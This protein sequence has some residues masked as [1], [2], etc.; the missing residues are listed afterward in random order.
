VLYGRDSER[1]RIG[2]LLDDARASRSGVVVVRGE[3]GIGKTALLD[4]AR[5]RAADMHVLS[6]RGVE[7]ESELPFAALHQLLRPAL[8]RIDRLPAPQA[9]AL[10]AALGL[11]EGA[12]EE[13][14]LVFAA[15][16]SLLAELAERRP[17]LCLV[18]D[19]HW[20]D[21]ASSDALRFVAR[22]LDAEGIA[23][24]FAARDDEV[25][26]FDAPGLP[27][28]EL[29]GLGAE[30]AATLLAAGAGVDAA[31]A[32]RD[33]L[34]EWTRGNALALVELPA[35]LTPDQLAGV[36]PLPEALPVTR[37]LEH[38]FLA[39]A[40]RL[41]EDT[42]RLLLVA[43]A[44]D[45]EDLAVVSRA[46]AELG[47]PPGALDAAEQAGLVEVHGVRI[48]F[49]HP[50]VRSAVYEAASSGER[51]AAH[52]ALAGVLAGN[53]EQADRRAWH[54]AWS[55]IGRDESVV[56]ALD[57]AAQRAEARNGHTAA[58]KAFA[59]AAELSNDP[60]ERGRRLVRAAV[61]L[62]RAG[63]DGQAVARAREAGG[64]VSEPA[65]RA[66]L[67]EV[68]GAAAIRS[69]RPAEV[70]GV[71]VD[72]ARAVAATDPA[73]A[74]DLLM[75]A[76]QAAWAGGDLAAYLG[77]AKLAAA[78][79]PQPEDETSALLARSLAG[80]AAMIEGDHATGVPILSEVRDWGA[81]A[82]SP[83]SAVWAS[84]AALWL[85]DGDG[86]AALLDR[87]A[88]V[89]RERGE[90]GTLADVLGMRAARLATVQD[91][92]QAAVAAR[93]AVELSRDLGAVNLELL[94]R[95]ALAIVAAWRGRDE[96]ARREARD[97]LARANAGGLQLRASTAVYALALTELAGARWEPALE[98]LDSLVADESGDLDPLVASLLPDRIEA[99]VRLG[100]I[101]AARAALPLLETYADYS[102]Q[103]SARARL[104]A[105]RAL[106]A[107]GDEET[108]AH[109]EEAVRLGAD[110]RPLDLAGIR[111]LYGE[112]LR[113]ERR[114]VEA[115]V[116]L[117]AALDAFERR[118]AEPWAERA[119]TEL[120]AAGEASSRRAPTGTGRLTAQELQVARLVAQGLS[121][122]EVA[123]Q[124]FLSPRTIDAHLR[125][126]FAKLELT[127]RTQLA[128][129]V[130]A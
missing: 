57:D 87:A 45:S 34:V 58:A 106:L 123:A 16:L 60:G 105:S 121:N 13:R 89:A 5:E 112:Y 122:K 78:E 130:L 99:A 85:G 24:V 124:L 61:N 77:I 22:R 74:I 1:D 28:L 95:A 119:R 102:G 120:R 41:P 7:A 92:D 69:G 29:Q 42:Q 127:S 104:A 10:R 17:V 56:A 35:A 32:V 36:Q 30:A 108:V 83:R 39:R 94:P 84:F 53:D 111:L 113:R 73:K 98:L 76:S 15:A 49:R 54:L 81:T 93:E 97:V 18:D 80:F 96:E 21:D 9:A 46:A 66:Q 79:V 118:G 48:E 114:P 33:R 88:A 43:A 23:M 82:A 91:L 50:L 71:L 65:L 2:A 37:E 59:H 100:R 19:A 101:E 6:V 103:P 90:L 129:L 40:R 75:V 27:S 68:H 26:A 128:R 52:G 4:D 70:V 126:V 86:F 107:D 47:V 72:A 44:D 20:L 116:Q 117:R 67:A 11:A 12:G 3:A 55:A 38:V 25:D 31:P 8:D 62:S 63:R 125:R 110:A 64:L 51:R 109:F 14:F 115:R